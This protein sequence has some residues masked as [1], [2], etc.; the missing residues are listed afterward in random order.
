MLDIV[1]GYVCRNCTDVDN[2]KK[3]IDPAHPKE[4]DPLHPQTKTQNGID[5]LGKTQ[6]SP[7]VILSGALSRPDAGNSTNS[8]SSSDDTSQ[9]SSRSSSYRATTGTRLNVSV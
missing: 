2:A 4:H 6:D 8:A 5:A 1:N 7:A 3:G 9:G